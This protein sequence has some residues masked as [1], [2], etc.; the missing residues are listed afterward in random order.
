MILCALIIWEILLALLLLF[1]LLPRADGT[2]R[3]Q[4]CT[5]TNFFG[6]AGEVFNRIGFVM[7]RKMLLTIKRLS[8]KK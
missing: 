1:V 3:V 7:E 2:T 8:E 5:R 4:T 6:G